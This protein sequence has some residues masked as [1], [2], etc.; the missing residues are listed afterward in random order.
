MEKTGLASVDKPWLEK[1][2]YDNEMPNV[3]MTAYDYL[4]EANKN[5][6]NDVALIYDALIDMEPTKIIY[7]KLF[8]LIDECS[9]SYIKLGIKKGDI[10]TVSLPS[11][12]EN[13]VS[14]YALNRI[15]AISNL[16]HP[17]VSQEELEFYLEEAESKIL[18]GYGNIKEKLEKIEYN[19]LK[20]VIIVDLKDNIKLTNKIK[21]LF[22]NLK[23]IK[24]NSNNNPLYISFKEFMK[25]GKT[26]K[27]VNVNHNGFL[28]AT[29]THTSGT[30]GKSKA[31]M[32]DSI[33]FNSSV[34]A[35]VKETN[36]FMRHDK[37]LLALPPFP[38]YIL[39]NGVHLALSRGIELIVVPQVDYDNI[40]IYFKK[41]KLNHLKGIPFII[42]K[43]EHDKGFDDVDLK[44][45]KFLISG[46]GKLLNEKEI[47][48]FLKKHNCKYS[49]ANGYGMSEVGGC[50][51]CMFD[52][53]EEINTVGRPLIGYNA[54][55]MSLD[56]KEELKYTENSVGEI[57]LT[58]PGVMQKYYKN[59]EATKE[60]MQVDGNVRWVKTG[61]LGQ[62]T[63]NGNLKVIGRI[64][65]MTFI[66][67]PKTN[68][69]SKVSHDYVENSLCENG[70]VLDSI[71]VAQ[72][73]KKTQNVLKA[74]IV[75]KD[76][77]YEK[78]VED[79]D[80]LCKTRFRKHVAPV[81]YIVVD[82]IPKT[83]AGKDDYR[84]VESFNNGNAEQVKMK[85]LYRKEV[86]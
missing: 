50:A 69:A 27:D 62:I 80:K 53:T 29:L 86:K 26:I 77:P 28:T 73:D 67:D 78:V 9:R 60:I 5:N 36:L 40:S 16:I 20:K 3:N 71:V 47:N 4:Y 19:K 41:Y 57:W 56:G 24:I 17:Q 85:V 51:T 10:V 30:S 64:K 63:E 68:T 54:K 72:N 32:T 75:V 74:Y 79:L 45:F 12:I 31:V 25:I 46:G 55:I 39:N 6:L 76:S 84:Y 38:L 48:I 11:C 61:D 21:L 23:N 66:F 42:E 82:N 2:K 58:G 81:E 34:S 13:I 33:A 15:G 44:D 65:R 35:I 22:K 37:E 18:L 1:I 7:K 59:D 49:I 43:I 83:S 8:K 70:N 14:F 52:N